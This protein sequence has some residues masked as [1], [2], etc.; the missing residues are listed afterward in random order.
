MVVGESAKV[1][2]PRVCL[3]HAVVWFIDGVSVTVCNDVCMCICA[4]A[5]LSVTGCEV[6]MYLPSTCAR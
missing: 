3:C 1:S 4:S 5:G 6:D 2:P